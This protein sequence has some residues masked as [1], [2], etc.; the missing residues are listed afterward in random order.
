MRLNSMNTY[1]PD[2]TALTNWNITTTTGQAPLQGSYKE[3]TITY[4]RNGNILTYQRWGSS[5]SVQDNLTYG[6]IAGTNK[7][8]QVADAVR[9]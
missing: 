3:G 2:A 4:D 1:L 7:L 6:Y 5:A 8:S 9:Y